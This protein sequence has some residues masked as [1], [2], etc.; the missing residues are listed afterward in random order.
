VTSATAALD[1][2]V[3][4]L[5][6]G[7]DPALAELAVAPDAVVERYGYHGQRGELV[8]RIVGGQAIAAWLALTNPLC[9][10][11][12]ETTPVWDDAAGVWRARYRITAEEFTN[13]GAWQ[14]ALA[15]DGRIAWLRHE[16]DDLPP[17]QRTP[18]DDHDHA[19]HDP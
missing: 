11:S 1:R 8:Q 4:A 3:K 9:C 7:R 14:F 5:N 2:W 17:E 15:P 12:G 6:N 19:G 10:F 13:G 18:S 16:P